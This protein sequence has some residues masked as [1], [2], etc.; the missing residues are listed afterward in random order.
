M[1]ERTTPKIRAR[2]GEFFIAEIIQELHRT[3]DVIVAE[4]KNDTVGMLSFNTNVNL[5]LL[6]EV[7][8]LRAFNFLQRYAPVSADGSLAQP[9]EMSVP[10]TAVARPT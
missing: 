3:R 1:L 5:E 7:Y 2:Y 4:F 8:D 6:D 9:E 10:I